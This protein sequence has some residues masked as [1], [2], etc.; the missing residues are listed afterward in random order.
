M[1]VVVAERLHAVFKT[2]VALRSFTID[3]AAAELMVAVRYHVDEVRAVDVL[4]H[5]L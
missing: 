2:A 3:A 4:V 1:L 5:R